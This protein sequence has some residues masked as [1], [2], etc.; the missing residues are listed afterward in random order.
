MRRLLIAGVL[1]TVLCACTH[2]GPANVVL[3]DPVDSAHSE[4]IAAG[5]AMVGV[6]V[7]I[8]ARV[9]CS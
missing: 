7:A 3:A 8:S 6:G 2:A 1:A 4:R 9:G 5:T